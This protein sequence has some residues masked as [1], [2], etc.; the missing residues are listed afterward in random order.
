MTAFNIS[1]LV[2]GIDTSSLI[3]QLM[4]A[5][6][7]PQTALQSQAQTDQNQIAAYQAVNTKLA[8]VQTAAK[9]LG[10]S[11]TWNATTATS[12]NASVSAT[13]STSAQPG[14]YTTFSVVKVA[15]AQVTTVTSGGAAV[16]DPAA[17][18]D[19]TGADGVSHHLALSDGSASAVA[20]AVNAAGLGVRA[21]LIST[22]SGAVLQ[23]TSTGT[24]TKSAF[25]ISG[26]AD[27][28]QNL[29]TAQDAQIAVGDPAAGGYTVSSSTNTFAGAVPGVTFTVSAPAS[30][31]TIAVSSNESSISDS[32]KA[33]V[34]AVNDALG[35]IS[36]DTG[37]G[38]ILSGDNT[39]E[40]LQQ[41]LL[42]VIS[43][44]TSTGG[45]LST[46][47]VGLT[48]TGTLTF[49]ADAFAAAYTAD[50]T[51][52][53]TALTALS[54]SMN[55]VATA[56]ADPNTGSV[57]QLI[58]SETT[59]VK[60]L[61]AQ[62]DDWTTRLADQKATLQTRY[63]AM[64]AALARLKSE[65]SYLSSMFEQSSANSSSSSSSSN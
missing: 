30:N 16:A 53:Q 44:G 58:N 4:A 10:Q 47:G 40:T 28:T 26:L 36:K 48:S 18:I 24:G 31:V 20:V 65:S 39:L 19:V 21:A 7:K 29:V 23:F 25:T 43:A 34:A 42:G 8:A 15:T 62:I 32:A 57:T 56:G 49:D 63:A 38:A 35:E 9:A 50:P 12:S 1:G 6:A 11:D 22:D 13:G 27:P 33:L 64:E 17:G 5:A 37:Q 52:T 55:S 51:G 61:N 3:D 14:S 2:S 46:Y 59:A 54:T 45:S 41:K 60:N